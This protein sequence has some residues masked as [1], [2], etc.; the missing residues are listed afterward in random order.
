MIISGFHNYNNYDSQITK[1]SC[2]LEFFVLLVINITE[3]KEKRESYWSYQNVPEIKFTCKDLICSANLIKLLNVIYCF[4]TSYATSSG[5]R[6]FHA[7]YLFS[8]S[9]AAIAYLKTVFPKTNT[10]KFFLSTENQLAKFYMQVNNKKN[11][12]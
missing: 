5:G 11:A 8:S 4:N 3:L 10:L 6:S 7:V 2:M 12:F 1:I 9:L